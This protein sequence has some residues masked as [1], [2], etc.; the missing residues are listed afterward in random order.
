MAIK[1]TKHNIYWNYFLALEEDLLTVS[2]YI[3]F[4]Q[5]NSNVFSL[6]LSRLLLAIASEIDVIARDYVKTLEPTAKAANI[7]DYKVQI[8]LHNKGFPND[9]A[10]MTRFGLEFQPWKNWNGNTNPDWWSAYNKVKHHRNE[11]FDRAT[12]HNV[13]NA[14]AGLF[15]LIIHS[16]RLKNLGE[17]RP[18][19]K[20]ITA[21]DSLASI[22]TYPSG[23]ALCFPPSLS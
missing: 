22:D 6:E 21:D 8:L 11:H 16:C 5:E 4:A 12:L 20:I 14:F 9:V 13:L 23:R 18:A 10:C 3:E 15:L 1:H 7:S 19:P 2:R 17:L